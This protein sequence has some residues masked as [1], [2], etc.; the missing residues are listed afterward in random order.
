MGIQ[1][2]S[3]LLIAV[4]IH[5]VTKKYAIPEGESITEDSILKLLE[6]IA[7]DKIASLKRSALR[8]AGDKHP[9]VFLHLF[10]AGQV[11]GVVR[12]RE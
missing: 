12:G 1:E 11:G 10:L 6:D 4:I 2:R 3:P 5:E 8:P 9:T 7:T